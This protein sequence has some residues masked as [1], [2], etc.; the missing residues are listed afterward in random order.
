MNMR[1][2]Q[3]VKNLTAFILGGAIPLVILA[4]I[5]YSQDLYSHR[6]DS[7]HLVIVNGATPVFAGT[8]QDGCQQKGIPMMTLPKGARVPV[9]RIDYL[10]NCATLD[11]SLPNGRTGYVVLG[12]GDVSVS[13]PL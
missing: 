8:G 3:R 13:P 11:V 2:S 6:D 4:I 9:R 10:K 1:A 7:K 5:L 12:D